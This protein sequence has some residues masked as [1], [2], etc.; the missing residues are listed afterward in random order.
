MK[1]KPAPAFCSRRHFVRASAFSLGSMAL[2]SLLQDE[3]LLAAPV[4]P[5]LGGERFD[6][7]PKPSH[8]SAQAKAVISL[9]MMG[10]PSQV[11]LMD[12]KPGMAKW[13]GK[14]F[15]GKIKYDNAAEASSTVFASPFKFRAHGQCGT[16]ISE[17]LP[18]LGS[19]VDD[20]A[21]IRSMHTGVNNHLQSM[22]A[23]NTGTFRGGYPSL[24]S[25]VSYALGSETKDLPGYVAMTHPAGLPQFAQQHWTN[26]WLPSIYQG[27]QVRASEPRILNLDPSDHLRG[28]AQRNQIDFIQS[29]NRDHLAQHPAELDLDARISSYELAG[30]MQTAA[31]E[32]FDISRESDATKKLYGIDQDATRDYGTRCLIARRLVERGVRCVQLLTIGQSWDHHGNIMTA[33]PNSCRE[34]DQ[35]AAALVKDLKALGLLDTT[36]VHWGG[37]MGRLPVAQNRISAKVGRDHNTYG[38]SMWVAGGGFKG[39]HVHGATDEWGHHA[40]EDIVNHYDYHATLL[41][42]LGFDHQKLI[43]KRNSQALSL[44]NN[45]GAEVIKELLA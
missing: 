4:K 16:E 39:G 31:S 13:D 9:F 33:L 28:E 19:I 12:P 6:L 1:Q 35:P 23:M 44:T 18:H 21:V 42:L 17:L 7:T 2:A 36:V 5:F 34:V 14:P 10:G 20:V 45:Q 27:V 37:E 8:R 26:G 29:L 38:F 24:G 22:W 3:N 25:W 40:V 30:R 11:D 43:Y 15:P 32:A 41:H